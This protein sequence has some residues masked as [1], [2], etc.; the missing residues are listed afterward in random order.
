MNAI[1][2]HRGQHTVAEYLAWPNGVRCELIDGV[3]Y[4]MSPA[5]VIEHQR[6][7]GALH[8]LLRQALEKRQD[9]GCSRCE[10]FTAPIDVV[11]SPKT[12][13]QPDLIAVCDPAKLA[14]GKYVDGAP[15]LAVEILSPATAVKD[16]REKL[17]LYEHHGVAE[18]LIIDPREFYAE[19]YRLNPD[20]RYGW[21]DILGSRDILDLMS[22]PG[23]DR[24]LGASFGWPDDD[25]DV[26]RQS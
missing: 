5:P 21:P 17:R 7:L 23:L 26:S 2:R 25:L 15:D 1:P 14:N 18:Y 16:K 24:S 4:D 3:V 13:V 10:L 12:V 9:G 11:L 6:V 20:G 8:Y 22:F 19:R